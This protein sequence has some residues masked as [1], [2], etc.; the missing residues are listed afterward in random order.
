MAEA[1]NEGRNSLKRLAAEVPDAHEL[2]SVLIQLEHIST[3]GADR[4]AAVMGG[5]WV[6]KA[7]EIAIA[8]KL[9]VLSDGD[10]MRL[11]APESGGPLST[12]GAKVLMGYTLGQF[13]PQTRADLERINSVRNAFAHAMRWIEFDTPEVAKLCMALELPNGYPLP[14]SAAASP[15]SRYLN[16]AIAISERLRLRVFM[17]ED[18]SDQQPPVSFQGALP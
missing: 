7:L 18:W 13:G 4:T 5:A 10:R 1:K 2:H 9:K 15:K 17:G 6:E 14:A 3:A 12:F 11:F 8:S 16:A